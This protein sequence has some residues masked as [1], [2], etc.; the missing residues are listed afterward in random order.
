VNSQKV[1]A[2]LRRLGVLGAV[3]RMALSAGA[4]LHTLV[5]A[6]RR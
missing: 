3:D 6:Q 5:V 1:R 2:V 4:G